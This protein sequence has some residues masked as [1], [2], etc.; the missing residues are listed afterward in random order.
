MSAM[1]LY[2]VTN[3]VLFSFLMTSEQIPQQ[4]I[5]W[6]TGSGPEPGSSFLPVRQHPAAGGRQRDGALVDRADHRADPVSSGR[7]P[8][9]SIRCIS[10]S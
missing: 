10:A 6:V 2:I 5:A 3:A 1:I 9:A 4:M 8:S 7:W